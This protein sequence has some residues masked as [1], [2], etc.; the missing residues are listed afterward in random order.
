MADS[1]S[2]FDHA[3][4]GT[5]NNAPLRGSFQ[6]CSVIARHRNRQRL[7]MLESSRVVAAYVAAASS[8]ARPRPSVHPFEP[9]GWGM[10]S[11]RRGQPCVYT[12]T[13]DGFWSSQIKPAEPTY[14][15]SG[16]WY[17]FRRTTYYY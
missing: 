15:V 5:K 14:G 8:F 3:Q 17:Q 9:L 1:A 6:T 12:R 11:P 13:A 16:L 4:Q 2:R 7:L 10:P